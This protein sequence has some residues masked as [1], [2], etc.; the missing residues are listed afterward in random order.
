MKDT[1]TLSMSTLMWRREAAPGDIGE[2]MTHMYTCHVEVNKLETW[3]R[4]THLDTRSVPTQR[5]HM[6][7]N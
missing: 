3:G 4:G 7:H 5:E 1:Q 6:Q 2:A